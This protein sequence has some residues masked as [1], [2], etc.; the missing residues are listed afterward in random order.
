MFPLFMIEESSNEIA[1]I[2]VVEKSLLLIFVSDLSGN[3]VPGLPVLNY[4][5][6]G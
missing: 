4:D 3:D 2:Q 6:K 5:I 1:I